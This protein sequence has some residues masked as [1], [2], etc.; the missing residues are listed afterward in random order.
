MNKP[1]L[2]HLVQLIVVD[3]DAQSKI[4]FKYVLWRRFN[5]WRLALSFNEMRW[6]NELFQQWTTAMI[7][8]LALWEL[9]SARFHAYIV[10]LKNT[11]IQFFF[12][13]GKTWYEIRLR[14]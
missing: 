14:I 13:D 7:T 10:P 5:K 9:S 3:D 6:R 8:F 4:L 12:I 1:Q 2:T 11:K